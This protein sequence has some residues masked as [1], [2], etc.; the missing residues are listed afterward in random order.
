MACQAVGLVEGVQGLLYSVSAVPGLAALHS[1][2]HSPTCAVDLKAS[3]FAA[4]W[5]ADRWRR[6]TVLAYTGVVTAAAVAVT[7]AAVVAPDAQVVT[8]ADGGCR[9]SVLGSR[10][11]QH[12]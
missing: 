11:L 7:F 9:L 12:P 3:R 5:A 2:E 8:P 1:A 4:G 6:D 10:G